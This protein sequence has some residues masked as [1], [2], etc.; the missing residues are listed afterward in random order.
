MEFITYPLDDRDFSA[1]DAELFHCTR[2][3][4]IFA[5]DDFSVS[6]TGTD[7]VI[8]LGTGIG[9]IRNGKYKGKAIAM[10]ESAQVDM[11]IPDAA[12]PR[13]DVLAIRFS[14][15]SNS[16]TVVVKN[17]KPES[18]PA[19][20]AIVQTEAVFELYICAVRREVGATSITAKDVTDLRLNPSYCGLMADSVTRVDTEAI[21]AQIMALIAKLRT[22]LQETENDTYYAGREYVDSTF[23]KNE[24]AEGKFLKKEEAETIYSKLERV[25]ENASPQSSFSEQTV[26]TDRSLAKA[27][28]VYVD[29]LS[30]NSG[31]TH[32]SSGL[33]PVNDQ[34]YATFYHSSSGTIFRRQCKASASGVYFSNGTNGQNESKTVMIPQ[35]IYAIF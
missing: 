7:N 12:Y 27:K 4:G 29:F 22:K 8:N 16:T 23:L 2:S 19:I 5:E 1:E 10:K 34:N 32:V 21:N 25:W 33:I 17:G 30:N 18:S 24:T 6:V 35:A 11:G 15:N 28:A 26:T 31:S 9:W 3:S 13:Y 14:A 20:P